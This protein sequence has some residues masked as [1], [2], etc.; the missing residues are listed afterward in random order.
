[1]R[2]W[3]KFVATGI[4]V[5]FVFEVIASNVDPQN[6]TFQ[7]PAWPIFLVLWYGF[8]HT[9]NYMVFGGRRL[10]VIAVAWGVIGTLLEIV[11]FRRVNPIVDPIVYAIM[12]TAPH[13]LARRKGDSS[14]PRP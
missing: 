13:L 12:F 2:P 9:V 1:M 4:V 5:A 11:V 7:N 3:L 14:T 10:W 8:L 6:R